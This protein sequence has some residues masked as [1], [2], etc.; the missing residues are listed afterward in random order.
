MPFTRESMV[1]AIAHAAICTAAR[2]DAAVRRSIAR[3]AMTSHR[4]PRMIGSFGLE[5]FDETCMGMHFAVICA[6]DMPRIDAADRAAAGRDPL[7]TGFIELYERACKQ[8]AYQPAPPSSIRCRPRTSRCCCSPG[9]P[10]R[11]RHRAT[12]QASPK[13]LPNSRH[14]IAAEYRPWRES[15]RMRARDARAFRAPGLVRGVDGA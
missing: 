10:T 7:C 13:A 5:R 8:I 9:G 12:R 6:E 1:A 14:L 3:Q 2:G 4:W 15:T 11:Q